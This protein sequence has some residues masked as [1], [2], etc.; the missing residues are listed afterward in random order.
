MS[1]VQLKDHPLYEINKS[2]EIRHIETKYVK[3]GQKNSK[4]ITYYQLFIAGGPRGS[5]RKR[6]VQTLLAETFGTEK[7]YN[8]SE[9]KICKP[10]KNC[11]T[12]NWFTEGKCS[13]KEPGMTC[14]VEPEFK[15]HK[16]ES[17][18]VKEEIKEEVLDTSIPADSLY[19]Y[20]LKRSVRLGKVISVVG[21][22][23][24]QD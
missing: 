10:E 4:G 23:F 16:W 5:L 21:D 22:Y 8:K 15:C 18:V 14:L 24:E 7:E 17:I 13:V 3:K 9:N 6:S 2:G 19:L 20:L 1:W 12:C 11:G